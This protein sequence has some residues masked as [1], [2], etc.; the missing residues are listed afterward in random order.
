MVVLVVWL[1]L[2]LFLLLFLL[3]SPAFGI[4]HLPI[5]LDCEASPMYWTMPVRVNF[6]LCVVFVVFGLFAGLVV[7]YE[8]QPVGLAEVIDASE[9]EFR[10]SG[11]QTVANV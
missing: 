1:C 10:G 8:S 3:T 9:S 4:C 5:R 6:S 7:C 11:G 2:V